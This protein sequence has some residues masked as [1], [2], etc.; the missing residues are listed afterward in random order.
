[1]M[2]IH[3]M[4]NPP[5]FCP[6]CREALSLRIIDTEQRLA[7]PASDCGF[8]H[9][10]NPIPV[11]AG[12]IRHG[13]RYLLARNA[14]WSEGTFSMITGFLEAGELPELAIRREIQ[15]EVGLT[16]GNL[17]FLGHYAMPKFNQLLIAYLVEAQGE[18]VLNAEL[19]E[20]R[21][22]THAEL[23]THDFGRLKLTAELAALVAANYPPPS[24]SGRLA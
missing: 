16:A 15:E 10:N 24:V 4:Y 14:A 3:T 11:V 6:H 23:L 21:Y 5:Q 12:F 22:L 17:S 19:V 13:E 7:C 18:V 9:W 2:G 1:M 8:V 20:V